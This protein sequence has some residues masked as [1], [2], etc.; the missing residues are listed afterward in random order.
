MDYNHMKRDIEKRENQVIKIVN[1]ILYLR[2]LTTYTST[3]Q[4][5]IIITLG[6]KGERHT[7]RKN[8]N[9]KSNKCH[10]IFDDTYYLYKYNIG[11]DY[12]QDRDGQTHKK[13]KIK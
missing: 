13:G 4:V 2:T 7:K 6:K 1:A 9:N 10:T 3:I 5:Q 12:H 8:L 11:I